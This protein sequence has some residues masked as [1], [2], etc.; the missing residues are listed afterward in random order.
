[1]TFMWMIFVLIVVITATA[2]IINKHF[3]FNYNDILCLITILGSFLSVLFFAIAI[4]QPLYLNATAVQKIKEREGIVFQTQNLSEYGDRVKLN[5][6]ILTYNDWILE[7]NARK[8]VWGWT[9][10]YYNF[11]M[12]SH[13][14]ILLV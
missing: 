10:W 4:L 1:M 13:T 12:T 14:L 6:W 7:I 8:E 11:D 3:Y 2:W 9:S 5:E